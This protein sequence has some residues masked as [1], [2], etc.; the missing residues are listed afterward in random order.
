MSAMVSNVVVLVWDGVEPFELGLLCEAWGVDRS[1]EGVP[2]MDFAVCAPQPGKVRTGFGFSLDVEHGLER[3]AAADLV[4]VA[5]SEGSATA[6]AQGASSAPP[7]VIE[8]VRAAVSRGARVLS[9]CN[10]AFVLGE[11]GLLDGRTCTT[12]WRLTDQ[13][14]R[15]FPLASVAPEVLYV[16]DGQ[17]VTSAGSAAGIDACLHVW[18]AEH[19]A[20]AA[21]TVARRMVVP[22]HRDGGQAQFIRSAVVEPQCETFG[23]VL[24]W[25]GE[26]LPDQLPVE[27]LAARFAMSPRT[28]ARRFRDEVGTTP[29]AW[30]TTQRVVRAEELLEATDHPVERIATEVGFGNAA[31]LRHHFV[32]AR[33]VSPQDYRRTFGR[34]AS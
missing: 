7:A 11:A 18:R 4:C 22:P 1:D 19:G 25:I 9:V 31:A 32:R 5:P 33:G 20:R 26:H 17:V 21:A 14:A 8:A 2:V 6:S 27:E 24:A 23:P 12:H 16:D 29:H 3:A 30:I 28:F 13:L 34:Q 10:A 15:R